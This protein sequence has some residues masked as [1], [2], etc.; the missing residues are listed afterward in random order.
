MADKK[1]SGK[2]FIIEVIVYLFM[3]V[4]ISFCVLTLFINKLSL[5]P[6][7]EGNII[8]QL[9]DLT[10]NVGFLVIDTSYQI[11]HLLAIVIAITILSA[12]WSIF[13]F[14]RLEKRTLELQE[15][16]DKE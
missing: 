2:N 9:H 10:Q 4:L 8:Q 5:A 14:N 7:K 11:E 16:F 13:K 1:T 3:V 15:K 6:H 12:I